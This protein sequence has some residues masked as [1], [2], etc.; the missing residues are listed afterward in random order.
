MIVDVGAKSLPVTVTEV[1]AIPLEGLIDTD[2]EVTLKTVEA[3]LLSESVAE[4]TF[5]P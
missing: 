2:A 5:P 1:P 4:T 3:V